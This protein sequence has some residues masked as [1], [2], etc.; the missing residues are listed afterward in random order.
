M[1]GIQ[2]RITAALLIFV[3]T[4]SFTTSFAKPVETPESVLGEFIVRLKKNRS[5]KNISETSLSQMV[6]SEV[7]TTIPEMNIVVVKRPL[8]EST[9]FSILKLKMNKNI[10]LVEPNFIYRISKKPNDPMYLQLWGLQNS[11]QNDANNQSGVAGV[12]I[13]A[14]RAWD[15]ETGSENTV[16]AVID[17]GVDYNHPDLRDNMWVNKAELYGT[18][19]VDDDAN[20]IVDDIHGANFVDVNNITGDPLDDHGHGSHCSGTIAGHGNDGRGIVG[21]N[22]KS[23]IMAVKFLSAD[24]GGT[25][26]GA[27]KAILYANKMGA[28]IMSNSWGGGGFSQA[29]KDAIHE[30]NTSGALFVAAA[31]NQSSNN[32]INPTYPASYEESN[33]VSVAALDNRGNLANFS[34]YGQKTVHIA[35]PGVNIYSSSV[36]GG[37]EVMSG[38][39]MATPHVSG[40][41]GL[42]LSHE[43]NLNAAGIKQRM[44]SSSRPLSNIK[45]RVSSSGMVNAY[46][47]LA[48]LKAPPD[49]N[50][51]D[52]WASMSVSIASEHPYKP[53]TRAT[54]EVNVPGAKEMAIFFDK[55]ETE[56]NYDTV[57]IYDA[58]GNLVAQLSGA[59]DGS[60]SP[61]ISGGYARIVFTSDDSFESNGFTITK[62]AYR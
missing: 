5:I 23:K 18:A 59:M 12:D 40:V 35:A 16:I 10:E 42:I 3:S 43:P 30:T 6:D 60:Y 34:N 14:E 51:P 22:W 31:G 46:Y 55:F 9:D 38:T 26:S 20:G 48:N 19:G 41:A 17:T 29:L 28:K 57:S 54:F 24:G 58:K 21:V 11:G 39:S 33:I 61:T 27:L 47:A 62:V 36:S 32:D 49:Q 45:R 37:Y 53:S 25:L 13:D 4:I 2:G 50:D 52:L 15:I 1:T 44:M 7:L 8:I 56:L